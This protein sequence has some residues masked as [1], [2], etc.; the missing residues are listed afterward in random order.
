MI[1]SQVTMLFTFRYVITTTTYAL[2]ARCQTLLNIHY[3]WDR[4][5]A[6]AAAL[7]IPPTSHDLKKCIENLPDVIWITIAIA[8]VAKGRHVQQ[9]CWFSRAL[10]SSFTFWCQFFQD[11]KIPKI[12]IRMRCTDRI[13][14]FSLSGT[15]LE[16]W[17][18]E[19]M[20]QISVS[21][22]TTLRC[23]NEESKKKKKTSGCARIASQC[24]KTELM[25]V[26]WKTFLRSKP[27]MDHLD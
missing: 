9:G 20:Y 4:W 12:C 21:N 25:Q 26:L 14:I 5:M 11:W 3:S 6:K 7:L 19:D 17:H 22:A 16:S 23:L 15:K 13:F 1:L 10:R 18:S 27:C 24:V 8:A 2:A